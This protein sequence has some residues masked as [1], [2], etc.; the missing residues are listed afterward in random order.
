M[1]DIPAGHRWARRITVLCAGVLIL[2]L[3]D[4]VLSDPLVNLET[5]WT[6]FD[7]AADRV[8]AGEQIYRP[9]DAEAE[10]LP[11]LY[12][13]FALLLS[14]PLAL[15]GFYGSFL[16]SAVG[17]LLAFA[18]GLRLF[19]KSERRP[20]DATTGMI[21]AT[22]SGAVVSSTLIGQYSGVYVLAFGLAAWLWSTDRQAFAGV[23]LAMLWLKP[24]IAIAVPVVLVW[25]RSWQSLRGFSAGTGALGLLSLPFGLSQWTGFVDNITMMA[26]LQQ[27]N[28]VPFEKMVTVLGAAQTT[29]GFSSQSAIAV[30]VFGVAA[31]ILGLSV[32]ALWTPDALAESHIRA[33]GGLA[34]FVVVA[35]PRLY[36]YDATL[37]AVGMFGLW[38]AAHVSGGGLAKRWL[39]LIGVLTW[40]FLWGGVFVGL[41][42]ALP[43]IA[44]AGLIASAVDSRKMAGKSAASPV[45]QGETNTAGPPVDEYVP[46]AQAA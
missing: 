31:L 37:V 34:V 12:P 5:D 45:I 28:I 41:N 39:P 32:L 15:F 4:W 43:V 30:V 16:V 21:V 42:R 33:F 36:F 25:S 46:P 10:P 22:A 38:A 1:G 13:P 7:A 24:N 6:A 2:M 3:A 40:V 29:L 20:Y 26:E 14:L 17:T 27:D 11:Y 8:F 18:A 35:N 23:A 9:Y 19:A 44:G